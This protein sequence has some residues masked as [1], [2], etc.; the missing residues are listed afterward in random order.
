MEEKTG[1]ASPSKLTA[2]Y[3]PVSPI[4]NALPRKALECPDHATLAEDHS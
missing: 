1:P 4:C 3:T 2:H